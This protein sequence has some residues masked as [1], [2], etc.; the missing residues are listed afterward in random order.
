MASP[1]ASP[2]AWA[3][4]AVVRAERPT[5]V[6]RLLE[7]GLRRG[8]HAAAPTLWV[9]SRSS[10]VPDIKL[11]AAPLAMDRGVI[12]APPSIFHW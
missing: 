1:L 2:S 3:G 6:L 7:R 12:Q 8:R 4:G 10:L 9:I 11:T 5:D